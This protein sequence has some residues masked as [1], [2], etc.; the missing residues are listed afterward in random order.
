MKK[1]QF[2]KVTNAV[3]AA[4]TAMALLAGC[5]SREVANS[6]SAAD[7]TGGKEATEQAAANE[8]SGSSVK[9]SSTESS[10][11]TSRKHS[12]VLMVM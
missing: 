12:C 6:A 9:E 2:R 4:A 11:N 1:D 7:T 3:I 8:A 5:G 10:K